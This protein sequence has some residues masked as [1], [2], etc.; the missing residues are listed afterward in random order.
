MRQSF[1]SPAPMGPVIAETQSDLSQCLDFNLRSSESRQCRRCAVIL[2]EQ[3]EILAQ[4]QGLADFPKK[5]NGKASHYS[6]VFNRDLR[7]K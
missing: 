3:P 2:K 7:Y 5:K 1:V 6:S 4:S